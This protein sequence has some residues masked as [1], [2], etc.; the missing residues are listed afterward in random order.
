MVVSPDSVAMNLLT[1]ML[2]PWVLF[3]K[4]ETVVAWLSVDTITELMLDTAT[5]G[6]CLMKVSNTTWVWG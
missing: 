6:F 2:V 4:I 1:I 3:V 5:V